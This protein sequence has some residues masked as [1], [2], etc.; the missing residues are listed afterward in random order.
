MINQTMGGDAGKSMAFS[1][2]KSVNRMDSTDALNYL[3]QLNYIIFN[4]IKKRS[5]NGHSKI[6]ING[7]L[8]YPR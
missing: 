5:N 7:N 6:N 1:I 4:E 8:R 3:K 2:L